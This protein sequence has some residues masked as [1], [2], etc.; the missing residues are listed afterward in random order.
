M[1][2]DRSVEYLSSLDPEITAVISYDD[3]IPNL[4]PFLW[5]I[6]K[7]LINKTIEPESFFSNFPAQH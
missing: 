4:F 3:E 2:N 7:I 6:V 5:T 1:M